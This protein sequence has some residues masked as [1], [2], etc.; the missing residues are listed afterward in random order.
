MF[1]YCLYLIHLNFLLL[2]DAVS[3]FLASQLSL[4]N[5]IGE[6]TGFLG[7]VGDARP[8]AISADNPEKTKKKSPMNK[9]KHKNVIFRHS[10][11][12]CNTAATSAFSR[13][14]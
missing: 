11:L 3:L 12:Y 13:K 14:S 5:L 10:F 7:V 2:L 8:Q 4:I 6:G 9:R 1:L